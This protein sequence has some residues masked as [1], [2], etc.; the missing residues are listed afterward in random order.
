MAGVRYQKAAAKWKTSMAS[1]GASY[2][3]GVQSVTT[4][5]TE[6]AAQNEQGYLQGVT[7]AVASGRFAKGLRRVSLQQWKDAAVQ[8]GASRLASGAAAAADKVSRF[9]TSFGPK[10][11][12]V[13]AQTNAMPS[14]TFEERMAKMTAQATAVHELKGNAY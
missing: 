7:E 5:P 2:T 13:T 6:L 10:L 14:N 1:A 3:D 8:K 12:Q 9:W 11:E 4:S